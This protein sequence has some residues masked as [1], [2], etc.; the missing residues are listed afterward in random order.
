MAGGGEREGNDKLLG[1]CH[2]ETM[3]EIEASSASTQGPS[4]S[5]GELL[6]H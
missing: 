6:L 1:P 3:K 4:S 5:S 2:K